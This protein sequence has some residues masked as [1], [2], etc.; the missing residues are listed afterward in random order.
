MKK[1]LNYI[2]TDEYLI[3]QREDLNEPSDTFLFHNNI[4]K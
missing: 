4:N 1:L 2:N 3:K